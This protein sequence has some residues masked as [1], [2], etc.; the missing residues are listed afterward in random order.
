MGLSG[1]AAYTV[2]NSQVG[3][4]IQSCF[5]AFVKP[6]EFLLRGDDSDTLRKRV[7]GP[8][9]LSFLSATEV[10]AIYAPRRSN[11][12]RLQRLCAGEGQQS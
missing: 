5:F 6:S 11:E 8:T 7:M 1:S 4:V 3:T 12:N 2:Y 9:Y 10:N